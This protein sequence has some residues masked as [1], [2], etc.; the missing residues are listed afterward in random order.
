MEVQKPFQRIR[1]GIGRFTEAECARLR[2]LPG[3]SGPLREYRYNRDSTRPDVP[4]LGESRVDGELDVI[5]TRQM[6][7]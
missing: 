7:L 4:L 1:D 6:F 5:Q 2:G 3:R